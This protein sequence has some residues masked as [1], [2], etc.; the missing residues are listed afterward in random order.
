M[1]LLMMIVTAVAIYAAGMATG[2]ARWHEPFDPFGKLRWAH[3][4]RADDAPKGGV[5]LLGDSFVQR[6]YLPELCGLPVFNAGMA[7]ARSDQIAPLVKPLIAKLEPKVI[8]VS[9]GANDREQGVEPDMGFVPKGAIVIG[10]D[11]PLPDQRMPDGVH[12]NAEGRAE[13]KRRLAAACP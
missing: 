12:P 11:V 1:K 5:L 4:N 9:A 6:L 3:L 10:V 8:V 2:Y 13:L 7:G